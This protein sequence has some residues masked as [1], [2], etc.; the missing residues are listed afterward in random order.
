MPVR[1]A[2][3]NARSTPLPHTRLLYRDPIL[4]QPG[5]PSRQ[6]RSRNR[7]RNMKL[8]ITIM[9][10]NNIPRPALLKKQQNLSIPSPHRAPTFSKIADNH[11]PK[12]L[13]VKPGRCGHILHIQRRLQNSFRLRLHTELPFT[14]QPHHTTATQNFI[15]RS[16]LE[17]CRTILKPTTPSLTQ[18]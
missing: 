6:F 14:T 17:Q 2:K 5:L 4:R 15:Q 16:L 12:D 1:V 3:I 10:R 11:K 8:A 9:R 7:K 13:L 18:P